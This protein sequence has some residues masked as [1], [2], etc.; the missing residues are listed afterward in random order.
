MARR[1]VSRALIAH[2]E[3][4]R[5]YGLTH[6][7]LVGLAG[8]ALAAPHPD[9]WRLLG[10]WG[11]PTLGWL[12]GLYGGDFFDRELDAV[13]K[14]QRPIP[15]GRMSARTALTA[16]VVCVSAGAVFG[17]LLNWRTI[18]L[19]AAALIAG[20]SYS[21]WFKARGLS[22]NLVRGGITACA[23]LFGTMMTSAYPPVR[24]LPLALLFCLHDAGSNLVGTLRDIEGDRAGG[25][26]TLPVKSGVSA[27][28][29]CGWVLYALW[30][31]IALF[32]PVLLSRHGNL[33]F[34]RPM[35]GVSAVLGACA[36][37]VIILAARP[38][39]PRT[40][41][42]AH[43]ILVIERVILG[44]ALVSLGAARP[45]LVLP[46]LVVVVLLTWTSQRLMR[47]R[48]EF[49][50]PRLAAPGQFSKVVG[51]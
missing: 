36:L 29:A 28:L 16:M 12:A 38:L 23:F 3:T 25:Y 26:Q 11:I 42:R 19:V 9:G 1:P 33:D 10:G 20:I 41:L 51:S 45:S 27:A 18:L 15:S 30:L 17:L 32:A 4:W 24:L 35:L 22:G 44:C 6:V 50:S 14:P 34:Y 2:L 8:A 39:P 5:P 31:V 46:L 7:G 40:A 37:L 47:A 48:Y 13:A 49:A 43:E 21:T